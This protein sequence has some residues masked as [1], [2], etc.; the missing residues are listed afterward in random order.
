MSKLIFGCGYLGSRV[1]RQWLAAGETVFAVTRSRQ[2]AHE[3]SDLGLEPLIA[4]VTDTASLRELPAADT[5]LYSVGYD[6]AGAP[7]RRQV[8]VEG[9]HNVL[10]ALPAATSR[11][12]YISSTG[13]YSQTDGQWVDED[14]FGEPAQESG[15]VCLDSERLLAASVWGPR[16]TILRLAG[17]YG[18]GRVPRQKELL[19]GEAIAAPREGYLNLIH[20]DDA[21]RIVLAAE[22]FDPPRLYTISDGHPPLRHEYYTEM[23]RLLAAPAPKFIEPP[24]HSPARLR[25]ESNK[26]VSN[27][28]MLAELDVTLEYPSYREGLAAILTAEAV[29]WTLRLR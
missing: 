21:A 10:A 29:E 1:A 13:V 15:Q 25:A 12:V 9:L 18:P 2:K 14:S 20:V 28:R 24:A 27:L 22:R 23:A 4:D 26:R 19:A 16:A 6:R 17:I 3:L 11:I 7:P 5:V 8:Y